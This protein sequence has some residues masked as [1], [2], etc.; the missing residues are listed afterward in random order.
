MS[1]PTQGQNHIPPEVA[2][3]LAA[4]I[5]RSVSIEPSGCWIRTRRDGTPHDWY[6]KVHTPV[7]GK[8]TYFYAHRI[9]FVRSH[10]PI[11]EGFTVDHLC[12]VPACCNPAH[13]RA[14]PHHANVLRSRTNFYAIN[15]RKTHCIHGHELPPYRRG[16]KRNCVECRRLAS[17]RYRARKRGAAA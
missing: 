1:H 8:R 9:M 2:S 17:A 7:D 6:T 13:L 3:N 14:V 12:E 4:L 16:G 15:A 10:G 5:L 11:P